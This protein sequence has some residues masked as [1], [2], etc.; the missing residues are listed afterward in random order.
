MVKKPTVVD[1]SLFM[2]WE[3]PSYSGEELFTK[4]NYEQLFRGRESRLRS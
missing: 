2:R 4:I 1:S 3:D